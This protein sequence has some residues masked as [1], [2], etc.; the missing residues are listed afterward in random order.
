[1]SI[2]TSALSILLLTA[3]PNVQAQ[4]EESFKKAAIPAS[5]TVAKSVK[6]IPRASTK[7]A[8][9]GVIIESSPES[10]TE[11]AL[12]QRTIDPK[13][14]FIVSGSRSSLGHFGQMLVERELSKLNGHPANVSLEDYLEWK[15]NAFMKGI[16]KG[17]TRNLHPL[18]IEALEKPLITLA[19]Q[20]TK[21]NQIQA[22]HLLGMN[23]NTLRKKI[24]QFK[25][26]VK[27]ER[28]QA[29]AV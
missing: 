4:M 6:S 29:L 19:L 7:H 21:G 2:R 15:I 22:A 14:T 20:E 27:R 25:I 26:P 9:D 16:N 3:D 12:L 17:V 5:V 10:L 24:A 1:M 13:R 11:L 23:R 18:L 28:A 8:F